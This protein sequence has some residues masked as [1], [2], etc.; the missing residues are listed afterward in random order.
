MRLIDLVTLIFYNLN[1]RKGRVALTA[2]GVIIG[3]AAVVLLV[4]LATGLQ[5]SATSQ[6]SGMVDLSLIT[7]NVKGGEGGMSEK[8]AGGGGGG[9]G[10]LSQSR[11]KMLTPQAIEEIKGLGGVDEI[12]PRDN[13]R[14]GGRVK[15]GRLETYPNIFALGSANLAALGYEL[16]DGSVATLERGTALI[17]E[18]V[19]E[20][21]VDPQQ[22]MRGGPYQPE[23]PEVLNQ[24]V[25]LILTRYTQD[26]QVIE[27]AIQVRIVG[28]LKQRQSESDYS[29]VVNLDDITSW[30]EWSM[31][32][33]IN[34]NK[35]GYD[36]L[37]VRSS[38]TK[39]IT[40]LAQKISDLGYLAYTPQQ[41]VQGINNFYTIIQ[42]VFGG[43]GAIALLVAAIGIANT[44][45]M[46]I[47]ERTRE[48]GLMKA[49]GATNR[50][51]MEIF[52]GEAAGIG[53][54]GGA[55]G[56]LLAWGAAQVINVIA[57]SYFQSQATPMSG[58]VAGPAA[59][60]APWLPLFA[61]VFSVLV[62]LVSGLYPALHAA[63]MIPIQ[64]LKYE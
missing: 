46:A 30:N 42:V 1:R 53:L 11:V 33:R 41:F 23:A 16:K 3:T 4:A 35:D 52:L 59:V 24:Q 9:G 21:F 58:P 2:V 54:I 51:V 27:K 5:R 64:A 48:I 6:F 55:G 47:L 18:T 50:N 62:G 63:T 10:G 38:D 61:L 43:I 31:N 25:K 14:M 39:Q 26:G 28:V 60:I 15:L 45:T 32:K 44:M 49:V 17:G 36:M 12:I 37:L 40:K 22:Q 34:R 56:V 8:F 13:L 57:A 29:L 20:N 19:A 7:V